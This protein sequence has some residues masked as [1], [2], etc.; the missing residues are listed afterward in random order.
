MNTCEEVFSCTDYDYDKY[1][2]AIYIY[3]D[4]MKAIL[5]A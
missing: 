2:L 1:K 3:I 5:V 4:F